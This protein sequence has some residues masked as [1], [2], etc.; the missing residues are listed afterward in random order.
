MGEGGSARNICM[1]KVLMNCPVRRTF[2]SQQLL[3]RHQNGARAGAH[4]N[5]HTSH[6]ND[7][8]AARKSRT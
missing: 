3:N 7:A 8:R 5:G 6:K 1:E 4:K 2:S